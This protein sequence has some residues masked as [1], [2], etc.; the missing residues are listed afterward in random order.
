MTETAVQQ[1]AQLITAWIGVRVKDEDAEKLHKIMS[2][3][4]ARLK[5]RDPDAYLR[6][7]E[8]QTGKSLA[9]WEELI[10]LLTIGE[11]YFFRDSGQFMLLRERILPE[12]IERQRNS[13]SLRIWS[14]GCST[15]EEAYS[16]AILIA[17]LLPRRE[18][19]AVSVLG[20]DINM[21]AIFSAQQ[22]VFSQWS[23]RGVKS[24]LKQR[25]FQQGAGTWTITDRIRDMVRFRRG[26]LVRDPFPSRATDVC[27]MDLILC[28]NVFLYFEQ[29]AIPPVVEKLAASLKPGGYLMTGHN[30]LHSGMS[31]YLQLLVFPWSVI[32]Q[33]PVRTA[34]RC[35]PLNLEEARRP[36]EVPAQYPLV[37]PTETTAQAG[38]VGSPM[39][40]QI[41]APVRSPLSE[42]QAHMR[43]GDYVT[44]L[45][46]LTPLLQ[47]QSRSFE[48]LYLM[49]Q[50]CANLGHHE[51]A[52]HSCR[53]ALEMAPLA[54]PPHY[55]LA[56]IEEEQGHVEEA[57]RLLRKVLYLDP[58]HVV[59]LLDLAAL[60]RKQGEVSRARACYEA[61]VDVLSR[62][63]PHAGI[64][65]YG[66]VTAGEL[67]RTVGKFLEAMAT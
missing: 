66:G 22:G 10:P 34:L 58:C 11:T 17:Q 26:N 5:L 1:F 45:E 36:Q 4:V 31:G 13:R 64:E 59:A 30:E 42:A 32:Y 44:A 6:L 50:A 23:F 8:M 46:R 53:E 56:H 19:W 12:L 43:Q 16:L 25:Y 14:A 60:Y 18:E 67:C 48:G 41:T 55:L 40:A 9:E 47:T 38:S 35:S 54:V 24:D 62:T 2:Q 65:S 27:D 49:A 15:G 52:A 51:H 28:R 33:R 57:M 3:R 37:Q 61:A 21:Q 29:R 20:N 63:E 7:L 39:A